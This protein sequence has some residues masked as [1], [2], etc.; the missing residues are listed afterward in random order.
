MNQAEYEHME[1]YMLACMKDSAHDKEHIYRV[2]YTAM[3][4]ASCETNVD[5]DVLIAA[6]LLHDIGRQEQYDNPA[7]CHAQVGAD[8]ALAFLV[9]SGYDA[10]FAQKV[11]DCI[12]S[13]RYRKGSM[14]PSLEGKI[15]FDADKVD[16]TGAH[17]I[18]RTLLYQGH[19]GHPLY[20]IEED[21]RVSDGTQDTIPSFFQEYKCKLE[22]LYQKFFTARGAEI[23]RD[24]QAAAKA[25][26]E[27]LLAE[28]K[29]TYQSQERLA[30]FLHE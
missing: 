26:Y 19:E 7:L 5:M 2:L 14:M 30:A 12:R 11:A 16:V 27:S 10:A 15:L 25:F 17:G 3:D 22:G 6:C 21:G 9:S 18:A 23:A 1:E 4:I 29:K 8:K 24:R 20:K 13:H 28:A